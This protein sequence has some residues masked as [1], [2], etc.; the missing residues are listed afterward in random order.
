LEIPVKTAQ[1]INIVKTQVI[2]KIDEAFPELGL[3]QI[4]QARVR[5]REKSG[6]DKLT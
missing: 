5:F 3:L 1:K 2:K 6:E 4:E